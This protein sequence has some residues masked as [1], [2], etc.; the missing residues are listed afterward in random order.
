MFHEYSFNWLDPIPSFK[1]FNSTQNPDTCVKISI[2]ASLIRWTDL[3]K[4][5]NK[6]YISRFVFIPSVICHFEYTIYGVFVIEQ[7]EHFRP[8]PLLNDI[9]PSI[10]FNLV[11]LFIFHSKR[12]AI[13]ITTTIRILY[14]LSVW[15]LWKDIHV[16]H[17][18]E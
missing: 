4:Q 14:S 5:P 3:K 17:S 9:S 8:F 16:F 11:F 1:T 6:L 15:M 12:K 7:K 13:V 10:L 18:N 2:V